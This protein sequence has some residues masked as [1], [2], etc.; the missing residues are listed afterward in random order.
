MNL[1]TNSDA[2]EQVKCTF[3]YLMVSSSDIYSLSTHSVPSLFWNETVNKKSNP[4]LSWR[5]Y[6]WK[7]DRSETSK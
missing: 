3:T 5:L 2:Y 7:G 4:I 1:K 6:F